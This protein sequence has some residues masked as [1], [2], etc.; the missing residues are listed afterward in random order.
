MQM[1]SLNIISNELCHT[2]SCLVKNLKDGI[3]NRIKNI[4]HFNV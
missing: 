4:L 1:I 2:M 3:K